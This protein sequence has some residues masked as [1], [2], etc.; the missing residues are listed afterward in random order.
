MRRAP[1][2]LGLHE[3]SP[4]SGWRWT[5][6]ADLAKLESGHTPSRR[7]PE[8]WGGE[9]PWLALPDIR[10]L[11][12]KTAFET[13]E[14]TNEL[15]LKNSSARLLPKDTIALS[16]TA[17]VGF[18]TRFGRPMATSQDFAN[19]ICGPD[20]DPGFLLYAIQGSRE[21]FQSIA[22]GAVHKTIYMPEIKDLRIAHPPKAEQERVVASLDE[23][24]KAVQD[25]SAAAINR[26]LVA[27]SLE[28]SQ[29]KT[30]F[31][32]QT[33]ISI[34]VPLQSAP[35]GW[36]WRRLTDLAQLESGHTPSR[37][38][39]DWW[40]GEIPWIALP[41]IRKMDGVVAHDTLEKTNALGIA[42]S[43]A[44]IL[45]VNTVVLS[46]TASV[47]YVT[48]LGR[49]MATSQDFVNFICGP[50]LD[51]R[52]LLHALRASRDYL[53]ANASGAIHRTLY[54]PAVKDFHLCLPDLPEQRRVA[55]SLDESLT[56]QKTLLEA[57]RRELAAIEALPAAILRTVFTDAA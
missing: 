9:T 31:L 24:F 42:N 40:G 7:M 10:E 35:S 6:I 8:W 57:S 33:P 46:R 54:M 45:P 26:K 50:E 5:R 29:F 3:W 55:G 53:V 47:G 15:G 39:P 48:I 30:A 23:N 19:W 12:G 43:S 13:K 41:D 17:S 52:F 56:A 36:R 49:E 32:E 27:D 4:R 38:R 22:S 18:A 1:I 11:N 21:Y 37:K 14:K 20:L 2:A 34:G 44:R 16:R 51:S 25:M 28:S